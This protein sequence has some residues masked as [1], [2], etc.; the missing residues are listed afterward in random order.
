MITKKRNPLT[1]TYCVNGSLITWKSI[2]RY[3]GVYINS[4][5]N[6]TDHV[7]ITAAKATRHFILLR[8]SLWGC[9]S[10]V[11]SLVYKASVRPYAA[12]VWNPYTRRNI[13]AIE[14][15]QHRAAC[16][17]AGSRWD[18]ISKFWTKSSEECISLLQWPSLETCHVFLCVSFLYE[19]LHK[20]YSSLSF[21]SFL[22]FRF[23]Q[24]KATFSLYCST[25]V[26]DQ[27]LSVLFFLSMLHLFRTRYHTVYCPSPK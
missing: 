26:H 5:L 12:Q 25:T 20:R 14:V 9:S 21:S 7:L 11:K 18:P 10:L 6:W 17:A 16:W 22:R 8:H 13:N 2:V 15:V 1:H 27:C 3:L 19:I 4:T 23:L 24:Y